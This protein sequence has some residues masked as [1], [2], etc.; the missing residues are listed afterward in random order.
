[1][2]IFYLHPNPIK[3]P[4]YL[5]NKHSVKMILETA[6]MLCTA[7]HIAGD[8]NDAPYKA[9]FVNHPSTKWA[10]SSKQNYQWLYDYFVSLCIEYHKRYNR[11]H[12]TA[13]KCIEPL[14]KVPHNIPDSGFTQPPQCMPDKYKTD[15]SLQAY[16][17]YYIGAK[18]HIAHSTEHV[19]THQP[20]Q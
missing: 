4:T 5:Y 15:C 6:Q 13:I 19:Y 14:E 10:R 11:T 20:K 18:S 3:A 2:N 9:A 16:W 12:M 7:H 1:M 17:R 8:P